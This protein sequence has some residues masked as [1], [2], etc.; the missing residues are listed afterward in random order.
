MKI[1]LTLDNPAHLVHS[2]LMPGML[3]TGTGWGG[4]DMQKRL[5]IV[6]KAMLR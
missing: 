6:E 2:L 3:P 5:K 1:F 4:E